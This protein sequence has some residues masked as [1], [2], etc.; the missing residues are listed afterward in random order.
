MTERADVTLWMA[1]LQ[2]GSERES[3]DQLQAHVDMLAEKANDGTITPGEDT[4]YKALIDVADL[5]SVLQLKAR[6]FLAS[7]RVM[8]DATRDLVCRR[9]R[10]GC[11]FCLLPQAAGVL[12]FH[13]DHIVADMACMMAHSW[14]T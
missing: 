1:R 12:T 3:V 9:A 8:D 6:R 2:Q 5:I 11:E 13:V 4:A 10:D 14:K 7:T